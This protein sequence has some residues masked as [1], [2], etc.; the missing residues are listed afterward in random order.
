MM[1]FRGT[2][3]SERDVSDHSPEAITDDLEAVLDDLEIGATDILANRA[4]VTP[5]IRLA[6]RQPKR[7]SRLILGPASSPRPTSPG[8]PDEPGM[9]ELMKANWSRFLEISMQVST[10]QLAAELDD[11]VAFARRCIDQKNYIAE[12]MASHQEEDWQLAASVKQPVLVL[13]AGFVGLTA[14][15]RAKEFAEQFPQGRFSSRPAGHWKP[16]YAHTTAR[17]VQVIEAVSYTHL[18]LPTT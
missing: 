14:A 3:M 5:A 17:S 13:D 10:G 2:G 9:L 15:G 7:V 4:R 16:P 18:T 6:V 1:D 8:H 11:H 12:L